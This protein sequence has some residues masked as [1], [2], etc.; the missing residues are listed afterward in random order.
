MRE[1]TNQLTTG[2]DRATDSTTA[3]VLKDRGWMLTLLCTT[4][5]TRLKLKFLF[6]QFLIPLFIS[7]CLEVLLEKI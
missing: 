7:H 4:L 3:A 5:E 6:V 1:I 2:E